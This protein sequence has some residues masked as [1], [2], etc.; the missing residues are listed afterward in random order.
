MRS[1]LTFLGLIWFQGNA[2]NSQVTFGRYGDGNGGCTSGRGVCSFSIVKDEEN[3]TANAVV[4]KIGNAEFSLRIPMK[5]ISI[6]DQ[7]KIA[8]M[9]FSELNLTEPLQFLQDQDLVLNTQT[10]TTMGIASEARVIASGKYTLEIKEDYI[11]IFFAL[12][13]QK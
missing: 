3:R 9:R 7:V 13:S 12:K 1:L 10:L 2:Q 5:S 11:L 8:G 6:E 4:N